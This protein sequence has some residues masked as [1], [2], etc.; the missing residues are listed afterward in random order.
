MN[1]YT[2]T[3][4]LRVSKKDKEIIIGLAN[5]KRLSVNG[6]IRYNIFKNINK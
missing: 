5:K 1:Q 4:H 2:E 6:Y 3:I